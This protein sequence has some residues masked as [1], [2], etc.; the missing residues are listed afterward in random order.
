MR[1]FLEMGGYGTYIWGSYLV[2]AL[3]MLLEVGLARRRFAAA[4]HASALDCEGN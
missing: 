2:T 3:V 4:L 1:E